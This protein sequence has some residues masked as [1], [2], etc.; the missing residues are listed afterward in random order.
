M[1]DMAKEVK[2][3]PYDSQ[4]RQAQSTHTRQRILDAARHLIL[5][6]GYRATTIGAVATK[7]GVS[8]DTIYALVG[9]KPVLLRE[10][11]EQA[12]S[13]TDEAVE[14]EQRDY[15]ISMR[16]EP[17]PAKKLAIYARAVG[18]IQARMAPL[19]LA[20]RDASSTESEAE[21]VWKD[22]SERRAANM[23]KLV[24]DLGDP[25]GLRAGVSFDDAADV[26]WAMASS[27][28]YVML[29][30]ERGWSP[31]RYERW[32]ADAWCRLLLE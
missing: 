21:R 3:R 10:L 20:L 28:L 23:G 11:I 12:I 17:E 1:E 7:A 32:L 13:G 26:V 30:A 18:A 29:T 19:F 2:P 16:A 15:V 8:V 9:R 24:R 25:G 22:I 4:R 14:A 31:D 5:E 27:E 6:R